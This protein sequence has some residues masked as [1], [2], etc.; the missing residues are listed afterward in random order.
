MCKCQQA[1]LWEIVRSVRRCTLACH[2]ELDALGTPQVRARLRALKS[3][4]Y[5]RSDA[6]L[7]H[8]VPM[9]HTIGPNPAVP[10]TILWSKHCIHTLTLLLLAASRRRGVLPSYMQQRSLLP[11]LVY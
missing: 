4:H 8:D 9:S 6:F 5:R 2:R 10:K 11:L 7:Q 3:P 1:D